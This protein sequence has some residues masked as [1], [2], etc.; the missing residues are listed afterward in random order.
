MCTPAKNFRVIAVGRLSVAEAVKTPKN[1]PVA[2][3]PGTTPSHQTRKASRA[4][5]RLVKKFTAKQL[6]HGAFA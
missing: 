4:N 1:V 3:Q 5:L 6:V 2:S